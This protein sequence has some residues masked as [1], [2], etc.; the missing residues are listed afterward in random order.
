MDY[1]KDGRYLYYVLEEN[2]P[3][4][5]VSYFFPPAEA[6]P[7][8]APATG[9]ETASPEGEPQGEPKLVAR[10]C[11]YEKDLR[12]DT[13][14]KL[15]F[16][17]QKELFCMDVDDA[18]ERVLFSGDLGEGPG[19]Y[20]VTLGTKEV[21]QIASG[22]CLWPKWLNES[23]IIYLQPSEDEAFGDAGV[24]G[25]LVRRDLKTGTVTP[26][27]EGVLGLDMPMLD[28]ARSNVVVTAA[29]E[30]PDPEA[31]NPLEEQPGLWQVAHVDLATGAKR[32]VSD[33][34]FGAQMASL[35][36]AGRRVAYMTPC[37]WVDEEL[38]AF[39]TIRIKDLETN[40]VSVPWRNEPERLLAQ[41]VELEQD[42]KLAEAVGT[43][44]QIAASTDEEYAVI[45]AQL[46]AAMLRLRP[47]LMDL[48]R[49]FPVINE[50]H[51]MNGMRP[52]DR[53][54]FWRPGD[55][56]ASDPEGDAIR[57]YGTPES[58]EQFK[59]DTD[60]ARD[61]TAL[62]ARCSADRLYLRLDFASERD[63]AGVLF[64]DL[65]ILFGNENP[66]EGE[67]MISPLAEWDR[68]SARQVFLRHWYRAGEKSQYDA[69]ILNGAGETISRF[70]ASGYDHPAYPHL[71]VHYANDGW[72]G[73]G[74]TLILS[75]PREILGL[76]D[77]AS[78]S[79]Q[80]CTFKGGV[81]PLGALERARELP[82]DAGA[83]C[84]VA[85]TF[86]AENTA[87]AIQGQAYGGT[88]RA[89]ITG[90]AAVLDLTP[91]SEKASPAEESAEAG[92][93]NENASGP[94][95]EEAPGEANPSVPP[96]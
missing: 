56:V 5:S 75:I 74:G 41:A 76:K 9:E 20:L 26:L 22:E 24:F 34:P 61:L 57:T 81:D 39:A 37:L 40:R 79:V 77:A 35:D 50:I 30:R 14:P 63:M 58:Q 38:L 49:A 12:K 47:P 69:Q 62:W 73:S 43:Y 16:D 1:S 95:Q 87:A 68:G 64:R 45:L 51:P 33:E 60:A 55:R 89:R 18:R 84:D 17:C 28:E 91:D 85:D 67:K 78:V 10:N 32:F 23:M 72:D 59:F 36:P 80:V 86:G 42:G 4:K 53:A 92:V 11:L 71:D 83:F 15:L 48:D 25:T 3:K 90:C 46:Y 29:T 93:P 13:P 7:V 66:D 94:G 52:K 96:R 44:D 31:R 21:R 27:C 65:L 88:G 54:L 8:A 2:Q 82:G 70:S 6:E 19:V